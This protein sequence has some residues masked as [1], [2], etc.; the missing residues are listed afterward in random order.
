MTDK[1]KYVVWYLVFR[2]WGQ[3]ISWGYT[4]GIDSQDIN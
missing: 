3:S 4:K 2:K 1:T